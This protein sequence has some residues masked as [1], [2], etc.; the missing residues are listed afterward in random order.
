MNIQFWSQS[1]TK[2][3]LSSTLQIAG[4]LYFHIIFC[5]WVLDVTSNVNK[6]YKFLKNKLIQIVI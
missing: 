2:Y 5:F 3:L 4:T 6:D 1:E